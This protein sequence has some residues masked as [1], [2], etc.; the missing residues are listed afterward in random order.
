MS[1][2]KPEEYIAIYVD[3]IC[4]ATATEVCFV[5]HPAYFLTRFEM[6]VGRKW[7]DTNAT[8]CLIWV[9]GWGGSVANTMAGAE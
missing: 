6:R 8:V 4:D 7:S 2:N 5:I 1:R 9:S 3:F